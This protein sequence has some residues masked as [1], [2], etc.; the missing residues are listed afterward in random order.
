MNE[1]LS[2]KQESLGLYDAISPEINIAQLDLVLNK[3]EQ[4]LPGDLSLNQKY[5]E[6]QSQFIIDTSKLDLV[7]KAAINEAR[8]RTKQHIALPEQENFA[9]EYVNNKVWSGYNWYKGNSYSLIQLNTD[10][11]IYIDRAIDLASHEGYPGHHVFNSQ[12]EQHLVND[13]GRIEYSVYPLFSPMSLLAEGSANYGIQVVFN[14]EDR[15][16]FEQDVLFP[17]A[18]L[19]ANKAQKYYQVQALKEEL[20]YIDNYVAAQYLDG[21]IDKP[22]AIELLMKYSLV[23]AKKA[24][25]RIGFI[26]ANRAYVINYNLGQDLV[27]KYVD[28]LT[29]T[30]DD[31]IRWNVFAELLAAPKT[32]SMMQ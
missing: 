21:I 20:S 25:Q 7:F 26:E 11:P 9:I 30:G 5:N 15:L 6:F 12:I 29:G 22:R 16:K 1:P 19:D 32:A 28:K 2:F 31:N 23:N 13:N 18:G 10:F 4:L 17:L 3:L 24:E 27:H 8:Q 14:A